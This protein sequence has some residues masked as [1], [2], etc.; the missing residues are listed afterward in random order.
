MV[1]MTIGVQEEKRRKKKKKI[2][3]GVVTYELWRTGGGLVD[4]IQCWFIYIRI[5]HPRRAN[6]RGG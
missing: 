4:K 2:F 1:R 5:T 3:M 6:Q